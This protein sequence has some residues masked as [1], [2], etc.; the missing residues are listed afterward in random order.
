MPQ[1]ALL[2][3]T[4]IWGATFPATKAALE[5][6]LPFSFLFLRFLLGT[7]LTLAIVL[8]TGGRLRLDRDLLRMSAIAT[9]FLFVGYATQT[10]GLRYTTASNS[11]FITALYVVFVPLF[12]GRFHVRTWAAAGLAV[13]GLW[14]LVDPTVSLNLGDLWTLV[15]AAAFAT[16]IC[17]LEAYTRRGDAVSLFGWQMVFVTLALLPA[18]AIE[19]PASVRLAPTSALLIALLVTGV[20]AT[21]AFAVQMWAQRVVPAHRVAFIFSLE[22]AFA[23]WLAW[24]FLG[25]RLDP[26]G[27]LGSGLILVA[28]LTECVGEERESVAAQAGSPSVVTE[29]QEAWR[30]S[31][32]TPDG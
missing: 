3:S 19:S 29:G 13:L 2:L 20:L 12:L 17:C 27:W 28:L 14:F 6:V 1:L 18:M 21:G 4:L 32:A 22:P 7:V 15:C 5:E 24:Y 8:G 23:A 30:R 10:V 31:S 16:H 11:A 9:V 25:E 26:G